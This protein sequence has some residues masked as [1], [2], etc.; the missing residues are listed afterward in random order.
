M[1]GCHFSYS[2]EYLLKHPKVLQSEAEECERS[3]KVT[4]YCDSVKNI[5]YDLTEALET[6][7]NNP[8]NFGQQIMQAQEELAVAK[9]KMH[10]IKSAQTKA[11]YQAA[12]QKVQVMLAAVAVDLVKVN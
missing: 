10:Q 2:Q 6:Q 3:S 12:L 5:S 8:L 1:S 11:A 4:S 9:E 7:Q